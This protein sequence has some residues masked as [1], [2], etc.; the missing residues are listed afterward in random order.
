LAENGADERCGNR[1][2]DRGANILTFHLTPPSYSDEY[3]E[4]KG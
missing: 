4:E 2:H 3:Y 1:D